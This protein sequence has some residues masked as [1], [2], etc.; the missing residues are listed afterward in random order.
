[1]VTYLKK[2]WYHRQTLT[3]PTR[4]ILLA[5]ATSRHHTLARLCSFTFYGDDLA[6]LDLVLSA[7]EIKDR[8]RS[9]NHVNTTGQAL[10]ASLR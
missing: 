10:R 9:V 2:F 7:S 5:F 8:R 4:A 6:L 3:L 1:M